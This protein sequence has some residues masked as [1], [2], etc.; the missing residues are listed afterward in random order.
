MLQEILIQYEEK[1]KENST[2]FSDIVSVSNEYFA[3]TRGKDTEF[4][5]REIS[6]DKK[7][8]KKPV[9]SPDPFVMYCFTPDGCEI[10]AITSPDS[11]SVPFKRVTLRFFDIK[12]GTFNERFSRYYY[13]C[14]KILYIQGIP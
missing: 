3:Y 7:K 9:K 14:S 2:G 1:A 8:K 4:I 11:A 6:Q 13:S 5:V 12:S 10:V